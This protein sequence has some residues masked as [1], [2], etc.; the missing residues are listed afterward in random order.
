[1]ML[2][3]PNVDRISRRR[4][5]TRREILDAAWALVREDGWGGLT[6]RGVGARVGMRAPSLYTH[7]DS[8]LA[9]VDAMF[10]QG[11]EELD[12]AMAELEK[13][14]PQDPRAALLEAGPQIFDAM[15][16]DADRFALMNQRPVPGFSPSAEAYAHAVRTLERFQRFLGGLGIDAPEAVDL[17]TALMAGLISQQ[18]AND[19]GGTRWRR[20]LPRVI[21]M[22]ADEVGVPST[23]NEGS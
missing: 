14:L 3:E 5:A 12:V 1:M 17:F 16:Q 18:I 23:K 15:G 20:L 19:P 7:F 8:K 21:T 13:R 6:L 9:I 22:Y 2:G 10:A 11:W 4:E